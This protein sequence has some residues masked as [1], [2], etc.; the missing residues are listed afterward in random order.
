M[1]RS[2]RYRCTTPGCPYTSDM[3]FVLCPTCGSGIAESYDA[4]EPVK[5][6][7]VGARAAAARDA[8][9]MGEAGH[10]VKLRDVDA[11]DR[12]RVKTGIGEFDRVCG[13]GLVTGS[14]VLIAGEPGA[15][16]STLLG[17][18]VDA[19]VNQGHRSIYVSGEESAGQIRL[20]AERLGLDL[21]T[22][23][24][25]AE[26]DAN[27]V[28]ATLAQERPAFAVIDSIQTL[29]PAADAIAGTP[30]S[31]QKVTQMLMKT[32]K[33][34]GTTLLIVGHVNKDSNVAGPKQLEHLVDA[35][36]LLEGDR[37]G[38]LR[39]LRGIKNRFGAIDEIGLFE[40]QEKGMVGIDTPTPL[41]VEGGE[42][43]GRAI[44]PVMEGTRPILVEVQALVSKSAYGTGRRVSIGVNEK[45]VAML[46]AVLERYAKIDLSSHDVYVE[47]SSGIV[48][49][50]PAISLAVCAAVASSFW[51]HPLDQTVAV[52]GE[53]GL[54]GELRP[55]RQISSRLKETSRQ[56][57][58]KLVGPRESGSTSSETTSYVAYRSL[59]EALAGLD[60]LA[61]KGAV[62]VPAGSPNKGAFFGRRGGHSNQQTEDPGDD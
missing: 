11:S 41:H 5:A 26:T 51:S 60:V 57:F 39:V 36:L 7:A 33:A 10:L 55:V 22:L 30:A 42:S 18:V 17:Q 6:T 15:G 3:R 58:V 45:R 56:G 12:T 27:V 53:V 49:N 38:F 28:V 8:V 43:H 54:G 1:A 25:L 31:V 44:I 16:K 46:L 29:S 34:T 21:S 32:A 61:P 19:L 35:V 52:V 47:V 9:A 20:R 4:P 62:G 24:V 59:A 50:E 14:L 13:G 48:V 40:M 2:T 37:H 23:E